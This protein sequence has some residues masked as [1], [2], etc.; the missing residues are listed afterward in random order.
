[1]A[2]MAVAD[3]LHELGIG[4]MHAGRQ[5]RADQDTAVAVN[6]HGVTRFAETNLFDTR[7]EE[8][9]DVADQDQ[10][11]DGTSGGRIENRDAHGDHEPVGFGVAIKIAD[12]GLTV[13]I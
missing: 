10:G 8:L 13:P 12:V 5:D 4:D 7:L 9:L 6:Q 1:M 11:A 3:G 2:T